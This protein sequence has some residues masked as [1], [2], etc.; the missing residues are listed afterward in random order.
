MLLD[1]Y[2]DSYIIYSILMKIFWFLFKKKK[3]NLANLKLKF[4]IPS[5]LTVT[6]TLTGKII[7]YKIIYSLKHSYPDDKIFFKKM[8]NMTHTF[9]SNKSHSE[10]L[11]NKCQ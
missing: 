3:K 4:S 9:I 8:C 6:K 5:L 11:A 1:F 7:C 2:V 10:F